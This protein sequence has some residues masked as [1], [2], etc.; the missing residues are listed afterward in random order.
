ML[1]SSDT[2]KPKKTFFSEWLE[3]LQQESWQLELLIS[4]LALFG[5]W[6]S[7]S[8]I[9]KLEYYFDSNIVDPYVGYTN[10]FM[11]VLQAGWAIFLT[12]LLIHIIIRGLWIGA[13]GLRYVSGDIDFNELNYSEVFKN[14]F[15]RRIGSFDDYIER[16]EKLS[17]VL[18]S[19]TFLLFFMSFSFVF[20]NIVFGI[21]FSTIKAVFYPNPT[22]NAVAL[23]VF[24][25]AFYG[26][27]F[28]VLIDFM[29]LGGFK[30]VKDKTFSRIYFWLYRFFSTISLSFIYRPLLLNFI[31]NKYT[32]KLFFLAIPYALIILFGVRLMSI[33]KYSYIPSHNTIR[34]YSFLVDKH[35]VHWNNYD[36]LRQQHHET[37]S[38]RDRA[39]EKSN[40]QIASLSNYEIRDAEL[41]VFLVYDRR[42]NSLLSRQIPEFS[43]FREEGLRHSMFSRG[44]VRDPE[45]QRLSRMEA[46]ELRALTSFVRG[47]EVP[48]SVLNKI[49]QED[50]SDYKNATQEN[51]ESLRNRI[52]NKY[53][54]LRKDY[55]DRKIE[56]AKLAIQNNFKIL[57]D[58]VNYQ[59]SINCY[60]YTHPNMHEKGLLCYVPVEDLPTGDHMMRIE[61]NLSRGNCTDNCPVREKYLPFRKL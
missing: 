11:F 9:Y 30:K 4:G 59:D 51:I 53:W 3:K 26:L 49:D 29:T 38:D 21:T 35:T 45:L 40:I 57:I 39:I 23:V 10:A 22:D 50:L 42:Y 47:G 1:T 6:E 5:I 27:G 24:A 55:N 61:K 60:F 18:F 13:I 43:I 19:F 52:E 7:R 46:N 17:S 58:E 36:D 15:L 54:N 14:Y 56:K 41:G 16:L 31:D 8:L 34:G 28:L 48:D 44:T 33:E 20:L 32:R 37:F 2:S 25:F 12:N